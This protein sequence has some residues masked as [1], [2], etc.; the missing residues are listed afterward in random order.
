MLLVLA[1]IAAALIWAFFDWKERRQQE[2]LSTMVVAFQKQNVLTVF[3]AQVATVVSSSNPRF[4]GLL[5]AEQIAIIP[6]TIEYRLD[7]SR[8]AANDMNWDPKTRRMSVTLPPLMIGAPNLNEAKA[9]YVRKGLLVSGGT[10]EEL[11]RLNTRSAAAMAV[12]EAR[13]PELLALAR[14][15]AR[16][17]MILNVS[18]PLKAA[19]LGDATVEVRFADEPSDDPSYIDKSRSY[20]EVL[21]DAEAKSRAGE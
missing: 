15:A 12:R 17:A 10:Q 18:V 2:A 7:L 13:N 20:N 8:M 1:A 11:T 4:Y 19:G 5:P 16:E 14:A 3:R 9:R 21:A 6:A